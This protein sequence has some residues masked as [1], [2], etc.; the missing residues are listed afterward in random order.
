MVIRLE[1]LTDGQRAVVDHEATAGPCRVVGG[2][3]SGLTTALAA[4]AHRLRQQ[5]RRPLLLGTADVVDFAIRVLN[6]HRD[7][8]VSL[9]AGAEQIAV[10]AE[11]VDP[12]LRAHVADAAAALVGYQA[13]F[14]GDE[15]L[16]V[17]ADAAGMLPAAEAL[18]ELAARY[19]RALASRDRV[20]AGGALVSA[21]LL[22]RDPA[23]LDD[24]RSRFDELLLDDFQLASF[25]INRLVSQLVGH[26]GPVTVAGNPDA[27]ISSAP[28]AS[29]GYLAAFDRRFG[30]ALDVLLDECHRSPGVPTLRIV[31]D[32][33][34]A[35]QAAREAIE[36]AAA[37]GIA[38][39]A[40]AVV[41]RDRAEATVGRSWS[42][43]VV[44]DATDGRWP[45]PRP[46][47]PWFDTELF[48][49]PDV[50]DEDARD[51]RWIALERRRFAVACTRATQSLVVI[52][53]MPVTAFVGDL[54]R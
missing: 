20:D 40:T 51:R 4:R 3:G 17:H 44:P 50:P 32:P 41:T 28:L 35:R 36:H 42:L 9:L 27:A 24:E 30:A 43:V 46:T 1:Q 34:G 48:H 38:P 45:S 22:L 12:P 14:L 47:D 7:R 29:A 18:I 37:L 8:S 26:G 13:S 10:V 54:V 16:R 39:E 52:A 19:Q 6:R 21:S 49:G 11:L 33:D 15:E 25:G 23:V 5:G 31:D 53:E 2:F